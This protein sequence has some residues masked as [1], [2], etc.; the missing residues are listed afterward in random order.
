MILSGEVEPHSSLAIARVLPATTS[1]DQLM[2]LKLALG[3]LLSG[4][5]DL[6][7]C[8]GLR[9]ELCQRIKDAVIPCPRTP[10]N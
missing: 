1:V 7:T 2:D 10:G 4:S 9:S 5:V 8:R 6:V 3:D